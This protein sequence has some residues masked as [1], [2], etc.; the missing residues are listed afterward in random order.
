MNVG[1]IIAKSRA[2]A[3]SFKEKGHSSVRLPVF[4]Y[5][6]WKAVY[7]HPDSGEVLNQYRIQTKRNWYLFHYLRGMGLEVIPVPV[8][9]TEFKAWLES[10]GHDMS[11]GH[12]AAHAV[13]DYVNN[14]GSPA[15]SCRHAQPKMGG[16]KLATVSIFGEDPDQPEVMSVALHNQD[17]YVLETLEILAADHSPEQA[18]Q[19]A[20]KFLDLHTPEAVFQDR[21]IRR[22]EFCADCNAL[23][24]NVASQEDISL[25]RQ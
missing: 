14:P 8:R 16:R 18:W 1:E 21:E 23:L 7:G 25:P 11:D 3:Q 2:M 12:E 24:V 5:E 13:G 17:G 6:D 10:S 20:E 19:K 15:T 22:P 4:S 9:D